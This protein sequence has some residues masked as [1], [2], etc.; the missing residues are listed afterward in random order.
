MNQ[1]FQP[2][3]GARTSVVA[4]PARDEVHHIGACLAA[5]DQQVGAQ[6]DHIVVLVNNTSDGTAALA[7]A[8]TPRSG[9]RLH[10]RETT[11]PAG[12]GNAGYARHLAMA[13]AAVIAGDDGVLLTTDAD[14]V[15]DSD[16]L[17]ANLRA[18]G[19]GADVVAGWVDLDP[20]DWGRIPMVLHEDDARECAYDALCDEIHARLDPDPAD[21]MPRH[22]QH[23]GASI[24]VTMAAYRRAGGVPPVA[25]GED[26]AFLAAL[27]SV[28]AKIRHAPECH[29]VV[30]GRTEGRAAGGMA[31]AIRRRMLAPDPHLDDRLEP[32]A[33]C[34]RRAAF[35]SQL[36]RCRTAPDLVRDFAVDADMSIALVAQALALPHFG[37]AWEMIEKASPRLRRRLVAAHDL[38]KEMAR[39]EVICAEL[40]AE[41]SASVAHR[42]NGRREVVRSAGVRGAVGYANPLI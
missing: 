36:R 9:T 27:R 40:R 5:L 35:R 16:W 26:R 6:F 37:A 23:S 42:V 2:D 39:A 18:I 28:D 41:D 4:I 32:A 14:G 13:E 17:A 34:A 1:L 29:V 22:T 31:D 11:L 10:V 33:D 38:A 7:R 25:C 15:V 8:M 19:A 30:S 3:S 21:P 24:A 20:L 12:H